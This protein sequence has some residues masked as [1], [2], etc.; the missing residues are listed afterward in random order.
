MQPLHATWRAWHGEKESGLAASTVPRQAGSRTGDVKQ[1]GQV[2]GPSASAMAEDDS[3][4]SDSSM[5]RR[6]S[7]S[8]VG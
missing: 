1:I 4:S 3:V 2:S 7:N 5:T 8:C 6:G